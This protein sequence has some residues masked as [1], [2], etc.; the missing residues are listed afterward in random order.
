ME[1][2]DVDVAYAL[3]FGCDIVK[4]SIIKDYA[5]NRM[6]LTNK[7]HSAIILKWS[8]KGNYW[9]AASC[10][11][12][13]ETWIRLVEEV[14]C[15]SIVLQEEAIHHAMDESKTLK[16]YLDG[17]N[18]VMMDLKSIEAEIIDEDLAVILLNLLPMWFEYFVDILLY[19]KIAYF[20]DSG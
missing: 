20:Y 9:G 12:L 11:C 10:W 19:G 13:K 2:E 1:T 17:L 5:R 6:D 3:Q 8:S 7:A 18:K 14:P 4:R 15:N 16:V